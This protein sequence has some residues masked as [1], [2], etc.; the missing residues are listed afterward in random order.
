MTIWILFV[1]AVGLCLRAFT[2]T[3]T[4]SFTL[5]SPSIFFPPPVFM[6]SSSSLSP[7]SRMNKAVTGGF[8]DHVGNRTTHHL[9]Y[10]ESAVDLSNGVHLVLLPFKLRDL[11]WVASALSTGE[12]KTYAF[13]ISQAY[14]ATKPKHLPLTPH[15]S[16]SNTTKPKSFPFLLCV[17]R[18]YMRVKDRVRAD[19]DKVRLNPFPKHHSCRP[20]L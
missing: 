12:I 11:Q 1:L 19:K 4:L 20:D 7:S 5:L 8:E 18:T 3:R 2:S 10:P 15:S 17:F 16:L 6:S 13:L 14:A 9:M